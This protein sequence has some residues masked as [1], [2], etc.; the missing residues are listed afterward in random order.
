MTELCKTELR[1]LSSILSPQAGR[2]GSNY[3]RRDR[4]LQSSLT[5]ITDYGLLGLLAL[6]QRERIKV[7]DY[8]DFQA[9]TKSLQARC[10]VLPALDGSRS[11]RRQFLV[12]LEIPLASDRASR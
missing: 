6:F 2:G 10:R 5:T 4:N 7:R 9:P 3:D 12:A 1:P 8:D 11:G